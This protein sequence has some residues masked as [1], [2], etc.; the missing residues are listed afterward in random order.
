MILL[1]LGNLITNGT[2]QAQTQQKHRENK[3]ALVIPMLDFS[4]ASL[5]DAIHFL[6]HKSKELDNAETQPEKKGFKIEFGNLSKT[7]KEKTITLVLQHIPIGDA[8][9]YTAMVA[10]V[11]MEVQENAVVLAEI[12][13]TLKRENNSIDD[14]LKEISKLSDTVI[15][16]EEYAFVIK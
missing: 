4:D 7:D 2:T 16:A 9:R 13:I 6:M 1:L 8:I 14:L 11:E 12:P 5:E 10:G 3:L 15:V